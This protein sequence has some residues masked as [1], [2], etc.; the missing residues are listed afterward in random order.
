MTLI[1]FF[2]TNIITLSLFKKC[3]LLVCVVL[4]NSSSTQNNQIQNIFP[5]LYLEGVIPFLV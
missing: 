1:S 2:D 4:F 3:S 5:F